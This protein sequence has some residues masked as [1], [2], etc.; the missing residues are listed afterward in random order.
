M[1]SPGTHDD[2]DHTDSPT[3]SMDIYEEAPPPVAER[4]RFMTGGSGSGKSTVRFVFLVPAIS[5]DRL[6]RVVAAP[7]LDSPS[8]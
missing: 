7:G 5:T 2:S 1:S 8:R 4:W 3:I 6:L